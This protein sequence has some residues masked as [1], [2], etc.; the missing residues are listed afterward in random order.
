MVEA[1]PLELYTH[2]GTHV[3]QFVA[4]VHAEEGRCEC[5]SEGYPLKAN[6]CA[7]K[8]SLT[9]RFTLYIQAPTFDQWAGGDWQSSIAQIL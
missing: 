8:T 9:V 4:H 5:R 1:N 2:L 7:R 3:F 6:P